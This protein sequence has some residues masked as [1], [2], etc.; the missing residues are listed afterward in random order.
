M[1][2]ENAK[3]LSEGYD[4]LV[5][6]SGGKDS[7]W[8]IVKCLEYGLKPLAVTWKTPARTE[9]GRRN[10]EN[11]VNLG[12]DHIDYQISPEVE[13]KFMYQAL[14]QHGSTAIPMHMAIFN[15]PLKLAI[16]FKIPLV[17]WGENSAFEYGGTEEEQKGFRL[18]SHWLRKFGV[19]NGTTAEDWVSDSLSRHELTP[20]F[21][22]TDEELEN[23]GVL[24]V[25]L[26]Y[27]FFWDVATSLRIAV[28]NG[29]RVREEGPKT[30]Y[31]N[32]ADIDDD[33]ISIH[34]WL[35]WYK[36]GF[37]RLWDNLSLEI[38]NERM[39]RKEAVKIISERGD[40]IPH[41]DIEKFCEFVGTSRKRFNEIC[42]KYRNRDIWSIDDGTWKIKNFLISDLKWQ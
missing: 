23:A 42:E 35:K 4:C 39:T 17:I 38:R 31:Y 5:P 40:E 41:E 21:G 27:Y 14:V 1:V 33:F 28:K 30:G 10:L 37:T 18:D 32:Y 34:H 13:R 8:Q 3:T 26:G 15:I 6:V 36:F 16:K 11:L 7:F 9:L 12:V 2:V 29:F 22:P 19:T 25:F 24:A 20:Y